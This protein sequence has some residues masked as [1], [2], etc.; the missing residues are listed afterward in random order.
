MLQ[1]VQTIDAQSYK[2]HKV[3][4]K[5]TLYG[6]ATENGLTVDQLIAANP[7]MEQP[8]FPKTSRIFLLLTSHRPVRTRPP[9]NVRS[10]FL[11]WI[12]DSRTTGK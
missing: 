1:T 8:G 2:N 5:E 3:K 12:R 11:R 10:R 9:M 6:I 4:K 7:G